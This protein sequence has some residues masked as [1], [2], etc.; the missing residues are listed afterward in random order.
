[1]TELTET[2]PSL[3]RSYQRLWQGWLH[4]YSSILAI[5]FVL[6]VVTGVAAAGYAKYIEWVVAALEVQSTSVIYWGPIGI[7]ALVIV[8]GLSQYAYQ[9]IQAFVLSLLNLTSQLR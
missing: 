4:P 8:K 2:A 1:M 5:S 9:I 7:I 6:M 3:R